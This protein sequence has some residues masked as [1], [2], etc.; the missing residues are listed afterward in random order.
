MQQIQCWVWPWDIIWSK[1]L[2]MQLSHHK[3]L[4]YGKEKERPLKTPNHKQFGDLPS[5]RQ[6]A[7]S[8]ISLCRRTEKEAN[9]WGY[10]FTFLD[11]FCKVGLSKDLCHPEHHQGILGTNQIR[12]EN[13]V[14]KANKELGVHQQVLL[15]K[16][17]PLKGGEPQ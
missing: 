9:G 17:S 10:T 3:C 4:G 13:S 5:P 7:A 11:H 16:G 15:N 1:P 8:S 12:A 6:L 14:Q 2:G